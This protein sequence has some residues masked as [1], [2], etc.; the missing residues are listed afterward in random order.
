MLNLHIRLL[1]FLRGLSHSL[2]T[3]SPKELLG[4]TGTSSLSLSPLS[5]APASCASGIQRAFSVRHPALAAQEPARAH[6]GDRVFIS[7][8]LEKVR[9][10]RNVAV[11][12]SLHWGV[13]SPVTKQTVHL[14]MSTFAHPHL[15]SIQ[16]LVAV[17]VWRSNDTAT[18]SNDDF[19]IFSKPPS[20]AWKDFNN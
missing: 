20:I 11:G 6:S 13:F 3:P 19:T 7:L 1:L 12:R 14:N 18:L 8:V 9:V 16:I 15:P 2:A 10:P 5:S 17:K 4:S